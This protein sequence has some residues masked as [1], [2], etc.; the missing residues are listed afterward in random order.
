MT[1]LNNLGEVARIQG[2]Y[3]Q[4]AQYYNQSLFIAE[5]IGSRIAIA[6]GLLNLGLVHASLDE[7]D[8]SAKY[9]YQ[10]LEKST[11]IG[12]I[13]IVLFTLTGI[14]GLL[15][16]AG[17]HERAAVLLGL[18]LGH[19]VVDAQNEREAEPILTMLRQELLDILK[20]LN[21]D[22]DGFYTVPPAVQASIA[23]W[24]EE[25]RINARGVKA[26]KKKW[27]DSDG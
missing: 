22:I 18:V 25:D 10:A 15:A 23:C 27:R 2:N 11:D 13:P 9:L 24:I 6:A 12:V 3:Q 17:R 26:K 5:E 4:A 7:A 1:C 21:E 14:A 16:K 8:V 19:P 20:Q